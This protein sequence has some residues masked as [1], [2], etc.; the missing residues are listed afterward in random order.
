VLK[1]AHESVRDEDGKPVYPLAINHEF[2]GTPIIRRDDQHTPVA[3][4]RQIER[5]VAM[6]HE[7]AVLVATCAG[8]G[9]RVS[10]A[11]SLTVGDTGA[12]SW[13]PQ[14][15]AIHIRKTLKTDAS[16][17]TVYI[18]RELNAFLSE[19]LGSRSRGEK[20][21]DVSR[22][23]VYR[24]LE[25]E[26]LPPCHAYRRY[27]ATWRDEAGMNGE[28]LKSLMGHSKGS[29]VTDRYKFTAKKTEF[30]IAEVERVGLGF[31]L[32]AVAA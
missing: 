1:L 14:E 22:S 16:A 32:P 4:R 15:S 21:L 27:F 23:D 10:E 8:A 9:L 28:V 17:R 25:G 5:G 31:K 29:D 18:P 6:P 30:V 7:L 12:D 3:T 20:M 19:R 11:L 2:C 13:E 26:N 24:M